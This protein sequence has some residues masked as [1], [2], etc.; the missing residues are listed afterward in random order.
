MKNPIAER[1]SD[2]LKRYHPFTSIK[3]S[4]LFEIAKNIHVLY[5]EKNDYLFKV[6]D[7]TH[8]TFYVV[9][10]GAIGLTITSDSDDILV[11]KC[12][13]GDILG[14]RPFFAKDNYLMNAKAREESIVYSIPIAVFKPIAMQNTNVLNFLLQSFASNTR[15]PLDK[16][17]KG[18]LLSEN[19]IYSEGTNEIQYYQPIHYTKNPI[20]TTSTDI[21]KHVAQMMSSRKIGSILVHENRLPI[22]I[23]TDK[24]LRS[25]IATGLFTIDTPINKIMSS[26]VITVAE[27]I[28]IVEAQMMMLKYNIGHLCVTKDGTTLSEITGIISEHDIVVAQANNPGVL[29]KQTKRAQNTRDLK[30]VREKVSNLIQHSIDKNI[31]IKHICSI[32][33]EIN[34]AI[35]KRAIEQAIE[36]IGTP[37]PSSFSWINIGSQGRKEQLLLSDQDNAIIFEDVSDERYDEVKKY[38][39]VLGKI[40]TNKLNKIGYEY[41]KDDMMANNPLWCKSLTD[42]KNQFKSWILNPREKKAVISTV[43]FDYDF[44]YGD[45]NLIHDITDTIFE[46]IIDNQLFLAYLGAD[47]LKNP[48]PLGFFRQFLVESDGEHKDTFDIK[49]RALLQLIDAARIMILSHGIRNI[50]N[51]AS[52]FAKL[53]EIEPANASIYEACEE[54]FLELIKFRTEEGLLYN[55]DGNYLNLKDL[56]KLDKVKLK[57]SFQPITHVQELIKNKFKLT[58]FT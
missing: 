29:L 45:E 6:N 4:D 38:F 58:Y 42:W 5:L 15:N 53:A 52:R 19:V 18:K 57:N 35:T 43:F 36:K 40:V 55:S 41:C 46:N 8:D 7:Q 30:I 39:L 20:I 21:V 28:S 13:E 44:V 32:V 3:H 47:A 24:D 56:S 54:A 33:G 49:S 17:H 1:I 16:N 31:P 34:I 2:F 48:P 22:G 9:A 10:S 12:D 25:K 11:D 23:I 14:L 26:P 37:P 50:N 51:T 27:N